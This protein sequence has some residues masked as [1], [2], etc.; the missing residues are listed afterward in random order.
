MSYEV[1]ARKYRPQQFGDVVGQQ[2][3]VQTLRNAVTSG[4]IANAYLFV[5]PRGTGKTTLARIMA[6]SLNCANRKKGESDPCDKC[7]SCSEIRDS[8]SLD[9]LEF[10]AASNTQ[11][12]KVRELIIDSVKY[13][14]ARDPYKIYIVDEVHMLSNSSF[15]ALLKTLEEPPPHVRFMFATTEVNKVPITILSR[16]QRFD[17]R[18]VAT[19]DIV[20]QL[21]K[22]AKTES[23]K[24]GDDA[25]IAIARGAEGGLRDAESALDQLI[26]FC[27]KEISEDDVL[28]VF[29]LVSRKALEDLA[30]AVLRGE[31]PPMLNQIAA[32]ESAGKDLSRLAL[33]L[34]DYFRNLLVTAHAG[35]AMNDQD[36]AD[37]QIETMKRQIG[38]A[39]PAK[40]LRIVEIL[41]ELQGTLKF[42]LARRTAVEVALIR[43]AR[44]VTV[45]SIDDVIK[46]VRQLQ[47][48]GYGGTASP[49]VLAPAAVR[50]MPPQNLQRAPAIAAQPKSPAPT[51]NELETLTTKWHEFIERAG[52]TAQLAKPALRDAKPLSISADHVVIGVDP[53]FAKHREI[54]ANPRTIS[55]LQAA[56]KAMFHRAFNIEIVVLGSSEK[57]LPA[58]HP[59]AQKNDGPKKSRQEWANQPEVKRALEAFNGGVVDVRE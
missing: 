46:M 13:K 43:A 49:P 26:S 27:G 45:A 48:G 57:S 29:G 56:L 44:T 52:E 59:A 40:L 28:A 8:R 4:R 3:I 5:G 7:S 23:V 35:G 55:G 18:R 9:V 20:G 2:H 11:V 34:L 25:L 38:L 21:G 36:I 47:T 33:E 32:I 54:L 17:L 53:E 39:D 30:D 6:K 12:D 42:A 51:G 37:A 15:N 31:I 58:D 22:I 10:D 50:E 1:L 14:P 41:I 24:I 19:R 16:C